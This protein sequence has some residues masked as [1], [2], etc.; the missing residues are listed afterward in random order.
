MI[1]S[2]IARL[3]AL[4]SPGTL[5]RP[6]P[7]PDPVATYI[8][9]QPPVERLTFEASILRLRSLNLIASYETPQIPDIMPQPGDEDISGVCF[10]STDISS[11]DLSHLMLPR[12]FIGRSAI[13]G[14]SFQNTDLTE[15]NLRW[16]DFVDVDFSYASLDGADL[17][18][19]LYERC[20]FSF[21]SL[22]GAD[23][24]R[25]DFLA[26]A[27]HGADLTGAKLTRRQAL[28]LKLTK[29]QFASLSLQS[30]DGPEPSGG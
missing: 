24:R 9:T 11:L 22:R 10:Y 30:S 7:G 2:L 8:S 5:A 25:V 19:S 3:T 13:M 26:C 1:G 28:G 6:E 21:S 12:T 23:C 20:N 29:E 18:A 17:R 4:L 15:A 27:F 16:N 14:S